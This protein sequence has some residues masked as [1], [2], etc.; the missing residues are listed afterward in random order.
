MPSA[1]GVSVTC[2][3]RAACSARSR[4]RSGSICWTRAR[5]SEPSRR[6]PAPSSTSGSAASRSSICAQVAGSAPSSAR[7]TVVTCWS[8][9]APRHS[10]SSSSGIWAASRR[11]PA[12]ER[13]EAAGETRRARAISCGAPAPCSPSGASRLRSASRIRSAART[14][15]R[16]SSAP[17]AER[18]WS[19]P[20]STASASSA[21]P[22]AVSG[23]ASRTE[24]VAV[25]AESTAVSSAASSD[26]ASGDASSVTSSAATWRKGSGSGAPPGGVEASRAGLCALRFCSSSSRPS[27]ARSLKSIR[28]A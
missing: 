28:R 9:T 12:R 21:V 6:H 4:D 14:C 11:A 3:P 17:R 15:H 20:A 18:S 1:S 23:R 27:G 7:I 5:T 13:E 24:C 26:R 22:G 25:K 16:L 8:V 10:F 2:R 19:I